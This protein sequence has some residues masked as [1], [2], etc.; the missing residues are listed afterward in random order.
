MPFVAFGKKYWRSLKLHMYLWNCVQNA[1][2]TKKTLLRV[3]WMCLADNHRAQKVV[4]L[5]PINPGVWRY[6][7]GCCDALFGLDGVP[8]EQKNVCTPWYVKLLTPFSSISAKITKNGGGDGRSVCWLELGEE[9]WGRIL[10]YY[11]TKA[12]KSASSSTTLLRSTENV[13][14]HLKYNMYQS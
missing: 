14:V 12:C 5:L 4:S 7:K 11:I 8:T 6:S 3:K 13:E 2:L 10:L 9:P 1:L